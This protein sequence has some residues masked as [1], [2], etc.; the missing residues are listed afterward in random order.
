MNAEVESNKASSTVS[1]N[2]SIYLTSQMNSILEY[3]RE[4]NEMTEEDVQELLDVK[5]TRAYL[6]MKQMHDMGLVDIAGRG[7]SKRYRIK[8]LQ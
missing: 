8:Y 7:D 2:K 1:E 6:V 3:L 4:K 5:R